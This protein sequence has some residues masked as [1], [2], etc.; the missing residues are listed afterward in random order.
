M[1]TRTPQFL[2]SRLCASASFQ[3]QLLHRLPLPP[4]GVSV[5]LDG[6]QST[7]LPGADGSLYA[8]RHEDQMYE[9]SSAA[10]G[11]RLLQAPAKL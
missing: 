7:I 8:F 5:G 1:A 10:E 9:V 2:T 4:Q 11:A 3:H 6:A